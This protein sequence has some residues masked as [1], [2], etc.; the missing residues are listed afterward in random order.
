LI[1]VVFAAFSALLGAQQT[2]EIVGMVT[3][4]TSAVLPHAT[5]TMTN[6]QSKDIRT[7]TSNAEGFFSFSG[8][9]SGDYSV[10]VESKG[11][12]AVEDTNIH[13]S[14]GD[15]RNLNIM[16]PVAT[17]NMSITVVAD[18]STIAVDSGDLS[19][20]VD[21]GDIRKLALTGRDVTELIKILPGFNQFT[22]FGGMQNKANYNSAVT[23]IASAVGNGTS[24]VGIPSRAGGADLTADGAHI[25]DPGCNCNS[26]QTV[27]SDMTAEVK[28]TSSAYGADQQT[29]PV[30][31]AAVGKAG[32]SSYHG[33]A[34]MHYRNGDLNSTDWEVKHLGQTK[35][36]EHY[37]YPGGQF[38]GPVPFTHKKLLVFAGY[39]YYN[40]E[41][42]EQT[43]NGLIKANVPTLSN[44]AG[45]FDP[46]LADNAAQCAAMSSSTS[47]WDPKTQTYHDSYRCQTFT[48]IATWVP[49]NGTTA[50]GSKVVPVTNEDISAYI[51]SGARALL[52]EVPKP[53]F[54]PTSAQDF[55]Y[56]KPLSNTTNGYMFHTRVD[57]NFSDSLKLYVS[58]NQQ[59]DLSGSPVMRWWLYP[60]A[61]DYPGDISVSDNS[62]TISGNLVKVFNAST[63]N[64]FLANWSYLNSPEVLGN[65]K[66]VD[67]IAT[68]YPFTYPSTSSILPSILSNGY[69]S[70]DFD[71][72][73][74]YD[75]GR[76]SY[77]IRKLQ[78]SVSDNFTKVF[79]THTLKVGASYYGVWDKEASFGQD[80]GP[81]GTISYN[82]SWSGPSG[83]FTKDPVVNFMTDLAEGF[84][85][86]SVTAPNMTAYTLGFYVQDDW[87]VNHRLTLNLGLRLTHDA[88]YTDATGVFGVPAWTSDW[89]KKD[90]ASGVTSLPGMR[91][92]GMDP[93]GGGIHTDPDVPMAGHT[94]NALFYAPRF[95]VAY[96]FFGTGKTVARGGLGVYY[97]GD[98]LGGSAKTGEPM[99]GTSCSTTNSLST[100]FL[101]QVTAATITCAGSTNGVTSGTAN[102]PDDHVEPRTL[103]YN[104]TI[105]QQTIGK[106][107]LEIS[108][109]GSQS[110]DLINPITGGMNS[111]VP[112]GTY[113]LADPNPA[114]KYYGKILP[115]NATNGTDDQATVDKQKQ[116]YLP[117]PNYS[118]LNLINHGAWA[119]YNA[120][121]VSW[122]KRQGHLTYNLNYAFSKTLGI[123]GNGIDPININNDYGVLNADRTHVLNMSYAYE[124]GQR[125]KKNKLVGAALNGW[126][127]SGITS[128]QSGPPIP[129]SFSESMGLQGTDATTN[130]KILNSD[131]STKTDFGTNKIGNANYL[132]TPG[133][134][135]FP[136][137]TCNP[138]KGLKS[139]QY[140]NPSCFSLPK[141]PAFDTTD[142]GANEGVLTALGE[143]GHMMPY[144]RGPA[145]FSSDLAAS[146]T[147]KIRENQSAEVK[148]SATNFLNHALTSFDQS[149][150]NNLNL[151]YTAGVLQTGS[152]SG[153]PWVY[154]VPNEKFGRRVLE[155]TVKY[156]F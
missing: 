137:L 46:T 115:L 43:S 71:I 1:A 31:I 134:T 6:T 131:G 16:L 5:V 127:V 104:F 4:K 20:T 78:P 53:N 15:R 69:W 23:G 81:N 54:T 30:V 89:Y 63:T 41:Y 102:D 136:K 19:S 118:T 92:K 36:D 47:G 107:Q 133:Y 125:F 33:S 142:G 143:N 87:K 65:E 105:S 79:K 108:Y 60:G 80:N 121:I 34:Y 62:K 86:Q 99:G 151:N 2:G 64:E 76:A 106:T 28:V 154:G 29:G 51:G 82:P 103:T 38:S 45:L 114:S 35:A 140:V 66:A 13:I 17:E 57:Y 111:Q 120:L 8:V 14:P 139:K 146:R 91:W 59:H 94:P 97:Y 144:F 150:A 148:F 113:M 73:A 124:V 83:A 141:A 72:P 138:G 50:A 12:Q 132:G 75:T 90:I 93:V 153:T 40:Q 135:L 42:P 122:N 61:V 98:G 18:Q 24:A 37:K 52:N 147:I 56:V 21:A 7:T 129:Q 128:L 110:S 58:Y 25:I 116:D 77:F 149:N 109:M 156:N 26:T 101:N 3:D 39:E 10:K 119:N 68:N 11:F 130:L 126:M 49:A 9:V 123:I 48:N 55:N 152:T 74:Q 84:S 88:P 155:M 32:T 70:T 145:Y 117:Y 44:R 85:V 96:D 67:K 95:G 27:N 22:N 100:S 112:I